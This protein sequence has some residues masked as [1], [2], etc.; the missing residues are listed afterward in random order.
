MRRK[1]K[2]YG[3]TGRRHE[4]NAPHHQ[5]REIMAATSI[6]EIVRLLGCRR[7]DLFNV[8]ETGNAIEIATAM[9]EPGINFWKELDD[10][11]GLFR[12][13]TGEAQP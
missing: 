3:W 1:L 2:V 11:R 6:A 4:A 13:S 12:R 8:C 10:V 9:T 7:S 5:T